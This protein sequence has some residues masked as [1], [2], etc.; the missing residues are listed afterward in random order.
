MTESF[1]EYLSHMDKIFKEYFVTPR[2]KY[3]VTWKNI[4]PCVIDE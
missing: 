1:L 3:L 2:I 4:L